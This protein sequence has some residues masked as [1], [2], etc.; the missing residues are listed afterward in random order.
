[1]RELPE[2]RL[3]FIEESKSTKTWIL[4]D[5]GLRYY[6]SGYTLYFML[7]VLLMFFQMRSKK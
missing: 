7:M 1:M 4:D 6:M 3:A 5:A 2:R